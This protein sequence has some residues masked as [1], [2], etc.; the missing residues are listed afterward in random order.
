MMKTLMENPQTLQMPE[1]NEH[2]KRNQEFADMM[3]AMQLIIEPQPAFTAQK[4]KEGQEKAS[5]T[6]AGENKIF[7]LKDQALDDFIADKAL[8][9]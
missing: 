6:P 5:A 1:S 9:R 4:A 8:H 3:T 2:K 7:A